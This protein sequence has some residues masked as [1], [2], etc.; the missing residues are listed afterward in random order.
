MK[1]LQISRIYFKSNQR[2]TYTSFSD[3][4]MVPLWR[5]WRPLLSFISI[6]RYVPCDGRPAQGACRALTRT[7][8]VY[9]P[10]FT[11]AKTGGASAAE[12]YRIVCD[13]VRR[14][15]PRHASR[16][17]SGGPWQPVSLLGSPLLIPMHT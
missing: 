15:L 6:C 2:M 12:K 16:Q 13:D 5:G 9:T 8:D 7:L 3:G 10:H 14:S 4:P 17:L 1:V 11:Q